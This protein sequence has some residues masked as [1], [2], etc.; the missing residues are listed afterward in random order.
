M[1]A[2][3]P[4]RIAGLVL[5][6]TFTALYLHTLDDGLRLGELQGG[7]LI[8]HQYAQVQGRFS[9]APGYPLYTMGGWLWFHGLRGLLG[10]DFNPIRILSSYS[11]LWA[12]VALALLY[13]LC[14]LATRDEE[15]PAGHWPLAFLSS[16]FFGLTYF[17]WYY[18]VTTEQ[19]TSSVA[20][21]LA[22]VLLA[23]RWDEARGR[24]GGQRDLL[25]LSLLMGIGL[26]HQ[27]TV[28]A[29]LPPLLW[30]VLAT[31]PGLL[32]RPRLVGLAVVLALLPLLSYSFVYI[33]GA[34]HPEWRGAEQWATTAQWF[35]SFISTSQGRGE[36][37]WSLH[38]FFTAEYPALMWREMTWP[39]LLV[40]FA[41]IAALG[42]RRAGLLYATIAIYLVFCWIDRL[43]N[44]YQVIMPVYALLALGVAAA[45]AWVLRRF[46]DRASRRWPVLA[47]VLLA[48]VGLVAYRGL[49]SY[50]RAYQNGRGDD[51]GLA[52]GLAILA[53]APP[54]GAQILA[55]Q[56]E[57]LSLEY[58]TQI[59]GQ[60]SDLRVID[61]VT[62]RDRLAD[63]FIA[64][65]RDALPIVPTNVA[66]SVHYTAIG[67]TLARITDAPSFDPPAGLRP[68]THDF[69]D[70]LRFLG[71]RLSRNAL[72]QQVVLLAW[73]ALRIPEHD[74][75]VS[76]R[77]GRGGQE[78]A[79]QD[80]P[81][82]VNGAYPTTRWT[83]GEIVADAYA[84][85]L[86][87]S[88][89]PDQLTVILYRQGEGGAFLN[90]DVARFPLVDLP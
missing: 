38:P 81:G 39:G 41:G 79:Q 47:A 83:P 5:V 9:N 75:A 29:I 84:F 31:E 3:R 40:G 18:A 85:A 54:T 55:T 8:T 76:V 62:A 37:A 67:P 24:A 33:R 51:L 27:I 19:Y 20:W 86:P 82:P 59:W 7:D 21:T 77:L 52:P 66:P 2:L 72:G 14:I 48:L 65:T 32:R 60:R 74:F 56:D 90:L 4:A 12:I 30:F 1:N 10:A 45:A 43:G 46:G 73:Q 44:W 89:R 35:F 63:S 36:L 23:F 58:L 28:L 57:A 88:Q 53:D 70:Q 78:I 61:A 26:A 17:F 13:C 6:L 11:T 69:G 68:L 34:Q 50:P 71:A 15:H 42:R 16:A 25:G 80:R 22:V 64:V 87:A 49:A